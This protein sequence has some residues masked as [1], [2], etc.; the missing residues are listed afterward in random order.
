MLFSQTELHQLLK[1]PLLV[2]HLL[3]HKAENKELTIVQFIALHYF[4]DTSND[5]DRDMRLPFKTSYCI[6]V[7]HSTTVPQSIVIPALRVAPATDITYA[8]SYSWNPSDYN[9]DIFRPPQLV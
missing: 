6:Q 7:L 4:S 1:I 3:E 9:M 8:P 5:D 2:Q